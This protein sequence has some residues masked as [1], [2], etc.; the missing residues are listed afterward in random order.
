MKKIGKEIKQNKSGAEENKEHFEIVGKR[1]RELRLM[2]DLS[3]KKLE[4]I[5]SLPSGT[6]HNIE[7]GNGGSG[8]NLLTIICYFVTNKGYSYKWL[9]DY[10]NEQHFKTED[11]HIYLDIDKSQ[12]IEISEEFTQTAKNLNKIV[13]KYK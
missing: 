7:H 3:I 12:L 11:Q 5:L 10:D 8:I 2:E 1:I 9:L 13:S 6:V 4:E